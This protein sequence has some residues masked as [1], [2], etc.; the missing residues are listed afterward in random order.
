MIHYRNS[1]LATVLFKNLNIDDSEN[2]G[3]NNNIEDI[4]ELRKG[5]IM[6][7][8]M[9]IYYVYG[10][11]YSKNIEV[12]LKFVN[13]SIRDLHF[14]PKELYYFINIL[15]R[16]EESGERKLENKEMLAEIAENLYPPA[17]GKEPFY[18]KV[19]AS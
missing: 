12:I 18:H 10:L 19:Q 1:T 6:T 16:A 14:Y 3:I 17:A 5:E 8:D 4:F 2:K 7:Q 11:Y 15:L 13:M 9:F